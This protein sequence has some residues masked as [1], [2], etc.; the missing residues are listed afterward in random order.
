MIWNKNF[1]TYRKSKIGLRKV[2]VSITPN[3]ARVA[4]LSVKFNLCLKGIEQLMINHV[5]QLQATLNERRS[6]NWCYTA[7]NYTPKLMVQLM[8]LYEEKYVDY[9]IMGFEI[10]TTT[11]TPHIQGYFHCKDAKQLVSL[12]HKF[13]TIH[14]EAMGGT[15]LQASDYC[16]KDGYYFEYGKLPK[17]GKSK[18][19]ELVVE[20]LRSGK[21]IEE[22]EELFPSFCLYHRSKLEAWYMQ[23]EQKKVYETEYYV[24][25]D[26]DPITAVLDA[27][28]NTP[29]ELAVV[30]ELSEINAYK[31]YDTVLLITGILEKKHLLYPRGVPITYKYG[32]ET[33]IIKCKRLIIS[34][35]YHAEYA[36][37]KLYKLI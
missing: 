1:K 5:N 16:K 15:S 32:Y 13:P 35:P 8:D 28:T 30:T 21:T 4:V 7:N 36:K 23:Q 17:D 3:P 26:Q 24:T 29:H 10:G 19:T 14:Y 18:T 33:R 11:H 12:K 31:K 9:H 20:A 6:H 25:D 22:M 34:T 2:G 37:T 27:L